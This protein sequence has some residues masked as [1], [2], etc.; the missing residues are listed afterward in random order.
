[1][2]GSVPTWSIAVQCLVAGS[3]LGMVGLQAGFVGPD[4]AER[5]AELRR[6]RVLWSLAWSVALA[7]VTLVNGL[8]PVA[9]P[10][11]HEP[12]L[13]VRFVALA[14][15]LVL[16]PLAIR[17]VVGGPSVRH[18]T[19]ATLTWY[20]TALALWLGTDLV[21]VGVGDNGLPVYGPLAG[22]VDSLPLVAIAVYVAAV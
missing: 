16:G 14:C 15:S 4:G 5:R 11:L 19:V 17:G 12:L 6:S 1:M 22:A 9:D 18:L 2:S 10:A 8:I 3:V 20:T 21:L 13:T 7:V